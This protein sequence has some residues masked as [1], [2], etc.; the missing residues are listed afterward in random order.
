MP[1]SPGSSGARCD[2]THEIQL[3]GDEGS[4]FLAVIVHRRSLCLS[5][6]TMDGRAIFPTR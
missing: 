4:D 1:S 6:E 3:D 2:T 5:V